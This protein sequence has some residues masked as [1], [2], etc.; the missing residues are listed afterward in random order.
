MKEKYISVYQ[1]ESTQCLE[2][3]TGKH[4]PDFKSISLADVVCDDGCI[5]DVNC[6]HCGHSGAFRIDSATEIDW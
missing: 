6:K 4:Q 2:S 5:L 3:P 1:R